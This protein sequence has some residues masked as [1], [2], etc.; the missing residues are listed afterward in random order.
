MGR[1]GKS[2]REQI[3]LSLAYV[4]EFDDLGV[5][6]GEGIKLDELYRETPTGKPITYI[7]AEW[8]IRIELIKRGPIAD[9]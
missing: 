1:Y 9:L 3:G 6:E 8:G 5:I 2:A 7:T 4:G